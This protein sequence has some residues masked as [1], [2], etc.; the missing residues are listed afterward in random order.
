VR[1]KPSSVRIFT[2]GRSGLLACYP[3]ALPLGRSELE[4]RYTGV[5]LS[6]F[7]LT[8]VKADGIRRLRTDFGLFLATILAIAI[9]LGV[10]L[11]YLVTR[12][13]ERLESDMVRFAAGEP[14]P[15]IETRHRDEIALLN[16]QFNDMARTIGQ[17]IAERRKAEEF[18]RTV[19]EDQTEMILRWKTDGTRTFVNAAYCRMFGGTAEELVGQNFL[20][21]LSEYDRTILIDKIRLLTPDMPVTTSVV[22]VVPRE[23]ELRWQEWTDRGIFDDKG[24]LVELQSTGRDVTERKK[25]EDKIWKLNTELEQR[26]AER[27]AE[28]TASNKELEAFSYSVSHDLRTP[29]RN[30]SGFV[31]MLQNNIGPVDGKTARYFATITS[32]AKR[33]G[34]L[35][36]DLL[37]LSRVG[38]TEIRKSSVDLNQLVRETRQDLSIEMR[39]RRIEWTLDPLPVVE[40][41]AGLLRQV[42]MN[43]LSNAIKYTRHQDPATIH[44]GVAASTSGR[45][46]I[47]IFI[48]DNGVGFD[49]KHADKLFGVFQRLHS[50]KQFEGTGIGLANVHRIIERHGGRVWVDAEPDRGATFYFS[51]P[52]STPAAG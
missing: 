38:R 49:M 24:R 40:A 30:I 39:D 10:S 19:I 33:M 45:A 52:F 43:L 6:Y 34:Q 31:G 26:V 14:V 11:H 37:A 42:L 8:Y 1:D 12:R 35:I 36:D 5:L 7:D 41:D 20:A 2:N 25:I 29:L 21:L 46:E 22:P 50:A 13:L 28:L 18:L 15:E 32:E 16:A 23:G 27:T 48:R 47:V 17:S 9:G 3:A 4:V 44:V 51:L